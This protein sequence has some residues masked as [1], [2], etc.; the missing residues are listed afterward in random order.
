MRGRVVNFLGGWQSWS[1]VSEVTIRTQSEPF[2]KPR[3]PSFRPGP[4]VL[5]PGTHPLWHL[6]SSDRW[7]SFGAA[8]FR[9][10]CRRQGWAV[11]AQSRSAWGLGFSLHR[12]PTRGDSGWP[13]ASL[14]QGSSG[15]ASSLPRRRGPATAAPTAPAL[16]PQLL[17]PANFPAAGASLRQPSAAGDWTAA[18]GRRRALLTARD[19]RG[20]WRA[21]IGCGLRQSRVE[22]R[23]APRGRPRADSALTAARPRLPRSPVA[24]A[25]LSGSFAERVGE[26]SARSG[27]LLSLSRGCR[28]A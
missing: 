16:R 20:L 5:W 8:K 4:P 19:T 17:T 9:T 25:P 11:S 28:R 10:S 3:A 18:A 15:A 1:C 27:Q 14:S 2:W 24:S 21:T 26:L 13:L 7:T 23:P 12:E 6:V 22:G